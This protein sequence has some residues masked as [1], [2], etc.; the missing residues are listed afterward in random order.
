MEIKLSDDSQKK[1]LEVEEVVKKMGVRPTTAE[2]IINDILFELSIDDLIPFRA[3][4]EEARRDPLKRRKV[5]KIFSLASTKG[6]K[7][8]PKGSDAAFDKGAG[9][10]TSARAEA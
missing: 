10:N 2:E 9:A 4:A 1:I 8:K 3:K 6:A 7:R 5:N